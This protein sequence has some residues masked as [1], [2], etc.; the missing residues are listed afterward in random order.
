MSNYW[1]GKDIHYAIEGYQ[2]AQ[3]L[4]MGCGITLS[5]WAAPG[6]KLT[7]NRYG[8]TPDPI[9]DLGYAFNPEPVSCP[10]CKVYMDGKLN[11][12][13]ECGALAVYSSCLACAEK[14]LDSIVCEICGDKA[15]TYYPIPHCKKD[16]CKIAC[17]KKWLDKR[18]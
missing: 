5:T 2:C 7:G 6:R 12:C 13:K 18:V 3:E 9:K 15:S 17:A 8:T 16:A 11:R 10:G 4:K 1:D 14:W